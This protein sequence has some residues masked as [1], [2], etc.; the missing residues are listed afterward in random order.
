[1]SDRIARSISWLHSRSEWEVAMLRGC[2]TFWERTL[3]TAEIGSKCWRD[4]VI[5]L[6]ILDQRIALLDDKIKRECEARR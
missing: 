2:A 3:A 5:R 4:S 6:A 1:M